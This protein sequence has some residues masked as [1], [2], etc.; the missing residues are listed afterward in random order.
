MQKIQLLNSTMVKWRNCLLEN[1]K[2]MVH[3]TLRIFS[4]C[5]LSIQR[6]KKSDLQSLSLVNLLQ[7]VMFLDGIITLDDF[8]NYSSI[9]RE[10]SEMIVTNIGNYTV[11]GPPPPSSSAV[12]QSIIQILH[13]YRNELD[14]VKRIK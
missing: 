9:V 14:E 7:C 4:T 3:K 10:E 2:K 8:K 13:S 5:M 11:C 12:T 1:L 6:A